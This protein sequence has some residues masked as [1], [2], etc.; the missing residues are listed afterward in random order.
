MKLQTGNVAGESRLRVC[1]VQETGDLCSGLITSSDGTFLISSLA[2]G[3]Y[4]VFAAGA[5]PVNASVV[6]GRETTANIVLPADPEQQQASV[7]APATGPGGT[8]AIAPATTPA[9]APVAAP[10]AVIKDNSFFHRLARVYLADWAGTAPGTAVPQSPRRGN[11]APIYSSPYP[12]TDWSIGGTV[13]I[14]VPD[15]QSYPLMQ[16]VDENKDINKIYGWVEVGANGST[17]NKSNAGQG[18]AANAPAAYDVYSNTVALDQATLFFERTEDTAQKDHF[19]WGYRATLLYGQDYRF[20]TSHGLLSQQLLVKN[21]Q[22]GFDPLMF[23][24][25]AYIPHIG[26][27]MVL[28]IGRYLSL[29]DIEAQLAP[30]NYSYSHSIVYSYDCAT[31]FGANATVK[32][33]DHWTVQGGISASCDTMPWTTDARPTGNVCVIYSWRHGGDALNTCDN[34]INDQK[35]AYNNLTGLYETWYHRFNDH[36][37]TDTEFLYQFMKDTPNMY[38]Y[39]AGYARTAKTP[40]PETTGSG[41]NLNFGAV[42]QDPRFAAAK[43]SATCYAPEWGVTN[44]LEHNFSNNMASLN[45]RNEV[46]DDIKGQ[47]TGTPAIYEEHMVGFDFWS[48]STITFRPE[49]SFTKC[50]SK[51]T[52]LDGKPVSCTNIAPGKSIASDTDEWISG[53]SAINPT[54]RG[55]TAAVTLAADLIW[56]F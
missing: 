20:T 11:P 18:I 36:W 56:H 8:P 21:A 40:W 49:V 23:Y 52:T 50:Y 4:H 42:C 7:A 33:N 9:T 39:N 19:D 6:A 10:A 38:W 16:A 26:Q 37:H 31:Q 3:S 55:K 17:N 46:V 27:G 15:G 1:R 5:V 53:P 22:Y 54:G 51:Y 45:I 30:G 12:G 34:A 13:V 32:V 25:D 29:P 41:S 24:Y 2:A 14:G 47:R 44:Y 28:R 35:Y 48:G 43:Q